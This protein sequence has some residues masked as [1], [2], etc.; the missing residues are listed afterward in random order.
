MSKRKLP[1]ELN[2]VTEFSK[3][4]TAILMIA[5]PV[6]AFLAGMSVQ[7]QLDAPL[8]RTDLVVQY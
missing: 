2:E 8:M 1:K 6:I 5:L 4:F 3:V 7:K